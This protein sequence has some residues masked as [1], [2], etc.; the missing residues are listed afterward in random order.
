MTP[1]LARGRAT[2]SVRK[3]WFGTGLACA[4]LVIAFACGCEPVLR[5]RGTVLD[6]AGHPL[7]G[8]SVVLQAQDR[9]PHKELSDKEGTFHIS[10]VGAERASV[11]FSK[12]GY[13]STAVDVKRDPPPLRIA[14]VR[15]LLNPA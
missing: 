1:D 15:G 5:V 13:R 3:R 2:R 8:V 9:G 4:I 6:R 10:I 11:T 14:P 12:D 7:D